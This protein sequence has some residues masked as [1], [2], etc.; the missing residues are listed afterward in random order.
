M[1][2]P[3][4][5]ASQIIRA[6]Y[7]Y[8]DL[9]G[10]EVLIRYFREPDLYDW[11]MLEAGDDPYGALDDV[12]AR[13]SD[14]SFE[15]IQAKFTVDGKEYALDWD[16]L[17]KKKPKGTSMLAKWSRALRDLG[18]LGRIYSAELRTNRLPAID[19]S[20]AMVGDMIDLRKL[21][22]ATRKKVEMECGGATEAINFFD[23][24]VF[25]S[26]DQ[27]LDRLERR[28]KSEL[29][30]GDLDQSGWTFFRDQVAR[31]ASR[32]GGPAPDGKI[33]HRHLTQI[34]THKRSE[35]IRQDFRV[36]YD[37]QVPSPEFNA[38]FRARIAD[39][40]TPIS[41]LWGTPG[42]GKSTY[43]SFLVNELQKAGK[44]VI[45]H[46]Y[47]LSAEDNAD[48]M[49]FF[50]ISN[51]LMGQ[52]FDRYPEAVVGTGGDYM[53][54]KRNLDAA[55]HHFHK[56]G[57]CLYL[58]IDGLDHVWRD[59]RKVD[60]L[61]FLFNTLLPLPP[62]L[63]LV[64]GTQRV[65][66]A[67]LP[68]RLVNPAREDDWIE[69]PAM[70][71]VAVHHWIDAQ[72]KSGRLIIASDFDEYRQKQV[73][74]IGT[75]FFNISYGH[76]LHLI[77]AFE[78]LVRTGQ[79]IR[80]E[81]V[82]HIPPCPDGDIRTYYSGLW[83]TLAPQSRSILHMLAGSEFHWPRFGV[84]Q[85][86]GVYDE[87][88]FL[89]ENRRSGIVP[90]HGSIFAFVRELDDHPD[91]FKAMLPKIVT[92]LET[93]APPFWKW[94]WLWLCQAKLG[95]F[96]PLM[97]GVSRDWA[98]N[99]LA[100]GWPERQAIKILEVAEA[101]AFSKGDLTRT[102]R[103]RS[104]KTRLMNA[105]EFQIQRFADFEEVA[106]AAADNVQHLTN[107]IDTLPSLS[108]D[109]VLML[110]RASPAA[111]R[112]E[113]VVECIEEYSRRVNTWIELHHRPQD[114]F[115]NLIHL[116]LDAI[117]LG[118]SPDLKRIM[119]FLNGFEDPCSFCRY[120]IER[121]GE[122]GKVDALVG[123]RKLLKT[124]L[125]E[126]ALHSEID[127]NLMRAWCLVGINPGS[128]IVPS[129]DVRSSLCA[130]WIRLHQHDTK[131][132]LHFKAVPKGLVKERYDYGLDISLRDFFH[133][134][135]FSALAT[136]LAAEGDF[137]FYYPGMPDAGLGW[138]RTAMSSLETTAREIANGALPTSFASPFLGAADLEDISLGRRASESEAAQ[139]RSFVAAL[140]KIALDLH[141]VGLK[142]GA[143]CEIDADTLE[144]ASSSIHW[145]DEF[146][147]ARMLEFQRPIVTK[148]AVSACLDC[149]EQRIASTI[150]E[151]NVRAEQWVE[152]ARLSLRYGLGQAPRLVRRAA[153]CLLGYGWRKDVWI[154][155]VL[156]AIKDV[157]DPATTPALDWITRIVPI[158]DKITEFTDGAGTHHARTKLIE[159]LAY[160]YPD[161]LPLL[162]KVDIAR[163]EWLYADK[164]L[165]YFA[166]VAD[167][168]DPATAALGSTMLD[169]HSLQALERA[170]ATNGDAAEI[171]QQQL[172]FLGG[173]PVDR[174]SQ[175]NTAS[176][177]EKKPSSKN[178]TKR[179]YK[180]F[181]LV[182]DDV[183]D[184]SLSSGEG[185]AY[186]NEWLMH[187]V[188]KGKGKEALDS[189]RAYF[190][191]EERTYHADEALDQA[192][193]VSLDVEGRDAAYWFI[194]RAQINRHGWQSNWTTSAEVMQRLRWASQY[195]PDRW[196]EFIRDTSEPPS[197]YKELGYGF[198]IGHQYL[199]KF[200][201]LVDQ[202]KLATGLVEEFVQT[203]VDEVHDQPIPKTPWFL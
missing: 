81:D 93:Q 24:F 152:L 107:L 71:Q 133:E 85:C 75:A 6:G 45:R 132:L 128:R 136:A 130:T 175:A 172:N 76:P 31:W 161:R 60:Q 146:W 34:I 79:A 116:L 73:E 112:E 140:R 44:A 163:D 143:A 41:I 154:F 190:R 62:G 18:A 37:Y 167:F 43:L 3:V 2:N 28:V 20:A 65:D 166:E 198:S 109:E 174:D 48:R 14:G 95:D 96:G 50:E 53:H 117:A 101:H 144:L 196:M 51:S 164:C 115:I 118:S 203:V 127:D 149:E 10:I 98:V 27:D 92:W 185:G 52:L 192:F 125:V 32:I 55:G 162:F 42:R 13:R 56:K 47:F 199:V 153:D 159:V 171:M 59:T 180:Q 108:D 119:S 21:D 19:F 90:F 4:I 131:L 170:A 189:I 69:I 102:V 17:L 147:R 151:F 67:Q 197:Y 148:E 83:N 66:K 178:S 82:Q 142:P 5:K 94:G 184:F 160:T 193:L 126:D 156:D 74:E 23:G 26:V 49:S 86:I 173:K 122:A 187:W 168:R 191:E 39:P 57:E 89:L 64:V 54:L 78:S 177:S 15:Y 183:D 124:G 188:S 40:R 106:I 181:D 135:F 111:M 129:D 165:T 35:P 29:V 80:V 88:A 72:D 150:S 63:I 58:V 68:A 182:V 25:R 200:L 36:P 7:E 176:T 105:R 91:I 141:F 12:V 123:M 201:L 137:E 16:W 186:F 8:Q 179:G 30:P 87:V 169:T 84:L 139:Y 77:Y 138:I 114:E 70:G 46:H 100:E 134:V 9:V 11:V 22:A 121:L 33:T 38:A 195:Y 104:I 202:R 1:A 194:V 103:L 145:S 113:V 99:S 97:S 120:F 61:N 155:D 110:A 157:H 158:V